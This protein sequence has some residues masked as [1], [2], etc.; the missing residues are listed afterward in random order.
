LTYVYPYYNA[1]GRQEEKGLT[2]ESFTVTKPSSVPFENSFANIG[3]LFEFETL[4]LFYNLAGK[5]FREAK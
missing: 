1:E 2:T 4:V 3:D 5:V